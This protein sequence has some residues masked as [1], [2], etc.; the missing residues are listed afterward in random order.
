MSNNRIPGFD[1]AGLCDFWNV[2]KILKRAAGNTHV[3]VFQET[4]EA[5]K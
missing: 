4:N 1:L 3:E 2:P 5:G